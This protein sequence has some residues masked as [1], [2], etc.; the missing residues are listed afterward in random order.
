MMQTM[1]MQEENGGVEPRPDLELS[2]QQRWQC[3]CYPYHDNHH[4]FDDD[5]HY[6]DQALPP[7]LRHSN[8]SALGL[9]TSPVVQVITSGNSFFSLINI[10]V[11]LL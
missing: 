5:N 6:Q 1:T 2:R 11:K 4:H 3:E 8:G 7:E 9:G 10:M